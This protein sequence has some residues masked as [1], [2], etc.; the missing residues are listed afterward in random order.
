M[1][2]ATSSFSLFCMRHSGC[3]TF[4]ISSNLEPANAFFLYISHCRQYPPTL[5]FLLVLTHTHTHIIAYQ[6]ISKRRKILFFF[7]L[8]AYNEREGE[9]KNKERKSNSL[10]DWSRVTV[11]IKSNYKCSFA[12]SLVFLS[13][14]EQQPLFFSSF[15]FLIFFLLCI[16]RRESAKR[17]DVC[18]YG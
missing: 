11:H 4:F 5:G 16:E 18:A 15:F 3:S 17:W 1:N 9:K 2:W 14:C 6:H 7:L 12:S 10:A 13:F 8:F